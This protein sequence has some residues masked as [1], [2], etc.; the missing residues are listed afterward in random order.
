MET[1]LRAVFWRNPAV[2]LNTTRQSYYS[3][4][5]PYDDRFTV[6]ADA[7]RTTAVSGTQTV[8]AGDVLFFWVQAKT[9]DSGGYYDVD[10]Y[11]SADSSMASFPAESSQNGLYAM[12]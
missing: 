10:A 11:R 7:E 8:P 4:H 9:Y 5:F 3:V 2:N 12:R 1:N 6:Y